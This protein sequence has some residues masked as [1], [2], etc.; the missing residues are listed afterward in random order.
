MLRVVAIAE[1]VALSCGPA[2]PIRD[3]EF[4]PMMYLFTPRPLWNVVTEESKVKVELELYSKGFFISALVG[5]VIIVRVSPDCGGEESSNSINAQE[6][7]PKP[8]EPEDS[9]RQPAG[10]LSV[11]C[12]PSVPFNGEE[13][14]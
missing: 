7:F 2:P 12:H 9:G 4:R 1:R 3:E 10:S 13:P 11:N 8:P 6:R 5:G 14:K